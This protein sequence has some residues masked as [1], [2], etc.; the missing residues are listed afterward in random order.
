MLR[1]SKNQIARYHD[2]KSVDSKKVA[3][4][5]RCVYEAFS[6]VCNYFSMDFSSLG[7]EN[8]LPFCQAYFPARKVCL[9]K[10]FDSRVSSSTLGEADQRSKSSF[11][12]P[13][14]ASPEVRFQM[15]MLSLLL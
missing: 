3:S 4:S 1:N 10:E 8:F 5:L 9:L 6:T 2:Y 14:S 7:E 13:T 11:A 12:N 15:A